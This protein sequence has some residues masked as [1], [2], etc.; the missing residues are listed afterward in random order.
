M[1]KTQ[2]QRNREHIARIRRKAHAFDK[3]VAARK[4]YVDAT[5]IYN[6]R[7]ELVREERGR[8]NWA[9][10]PDREYAVMGEAQSIWHRTAQELADAAL[11]VER[12]ERQAGE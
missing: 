4:A 6:A 2:V 5:A 10:K 3:I 12:A 9:M 1:T 8:G 7:L 11:S